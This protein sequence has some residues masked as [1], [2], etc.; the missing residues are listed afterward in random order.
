MEDGKRILHL[1]FAIL[2]FSSRLS[3]RLCAF[4]VGWIHYEAAEPVGVPGF[5]DNR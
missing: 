3:S 5:S 1:L 4:A 2:A